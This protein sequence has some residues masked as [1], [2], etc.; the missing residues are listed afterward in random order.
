[1]ENSK[2][3]YGSY[4]MLLTEEVSIFGDLLFM[5]HIVSRAINRRS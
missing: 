4:H 1:M 2:K 3:T 5:D